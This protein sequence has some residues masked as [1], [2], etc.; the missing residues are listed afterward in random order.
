MITTIDGADDGGL[1]VGDAALGSSGPSV[2]CPSPSSM[3]GGT[4]LNLP[5]ATTN[6]Y[7]PALADIDQGG[8]KAWLPFALVQRFRQRQ[9][10]RVRLFPDLGLWYVSGLTLEDTHLVRVSGRVAVY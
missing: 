3:L 8:A 10:S 5:L 1:R 2:A 9:I 4:D 6:P 7:A